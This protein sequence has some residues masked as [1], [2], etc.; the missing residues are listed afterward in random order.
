ML[1]E[2]KFA[3]LSSFI[4]NTSGQ[5]STHFPQPIHSSSSMI[6]IIGHSFNLSYRRSNCYQNPQIRFGPD[7]MRF[8]NIG[9]Q[10]IARIC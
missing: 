8:T 7:A 6:V 3:S 1:Q 10:N 9:N 4:L 2:A 5:S